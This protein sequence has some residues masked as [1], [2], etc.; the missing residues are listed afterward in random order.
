M[1]QA[2][3]HVEP[4][5][6]AAYQNPL[7]PQARAQVLE[8][9]LVSDRKVVV[10]D[11]SRGGGLGGRSGGNE[12]QFDAVFPS[13]AEEKS[14]TWQAKAHDVKTLRSDSK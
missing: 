6:V 8:D 14:V 10:L 4:C 12:F 3:P 5:R 9:L 11:R 7:G 2:V 13:L 1:Q